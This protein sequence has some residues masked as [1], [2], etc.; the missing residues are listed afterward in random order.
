MAQPRVLIVNGRYALS[1]TPKIGGMADVYE[2]TDVLEGHRKVAVK[3]F[4]QGHLQ[5]DI[6]EESFKRETQ[7]LK[8]L[9]HPGIVDL[10]DAGMD[11]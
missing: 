3:L 6:L 2:A 1:P 5:D 8:E 9:K 11:L 7:A 10:L 4:R